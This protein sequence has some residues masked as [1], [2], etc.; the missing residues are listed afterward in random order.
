MQKAIDESKVSDQLGV[1]ASTEAKFE[2][3]ANQII[4]NYYHKYIAPPNDHQAFKMVAILTDSDPPP[5]FEGK[6][7]TPARKRQMLADFEAVNNA[8]KKW[9]YNYWGP[10][11]Y[12]KY[13]DYFPLIAIADD[14][15]QEELQREIHNNLH[16]FKL[17]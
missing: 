6:D 13:K 3:E 16:R 11:F 14:I 4:D 15:D 7:Y 5:N 9:L 8:A 17:E 1:A 12:S 10:R 2:K